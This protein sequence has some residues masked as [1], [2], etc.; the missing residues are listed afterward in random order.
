MLPLTPLAESMDA[1]L[2]AVS[3]LTLE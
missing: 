3:E 1:A 2:L